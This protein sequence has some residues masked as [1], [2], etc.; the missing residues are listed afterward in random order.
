MAA[1]KLKIERVGPKAWKFECAPEE[2]RHMD[3][4]DSGVDLLEEGHDEEAEK[5]FKAIIH[6]WPLH[7]DAHHHLALLLLGRGELAAALDLWARPPISAC[8]ACPGNSL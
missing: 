1:R 4:F 3:K 7:I 6:A 2:Y 8:G 5:I